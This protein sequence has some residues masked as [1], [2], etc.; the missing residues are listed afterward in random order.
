MWSQNLNTSKWEEKK[1]KLPKGVYNSLRQDLEDLIF[2]SKCLDGTSYL[3]IN[4]LNNI[5]DVFKYDTFDNLT[6]YIDSQYSNDN[7]DLPINDT[8]ID[9]YRKYSLEYGL[10]LKNLFTPERTIK[11]SI[12]NFLTVDIATTEEIEFLTSPKPGLKI[13]N[14]RVKPNH[15]VLV[16]DQQTIVTLP[17]TTNPDVYFDGNYYIIEEDTNTT[18]YFFYNQENGIYKFINNSLVKESDLDEYED[19]VRY[20]IYVKLGE[21][22]KEKQYHLSRLKGGFYPSVDNNDPVEFLENK[23]WLLRNKVEYQNILDIDIYD[24]LRHSNQ[25]LNDDID[26]II[27]QRSVYVGEF[28]SILIHQDEHTNS[29]FTPNQG[30]LN[31]IENEVKND[32]FSI[33]E[34]NNYYWAVGEKGTILR[35]DK[36]DLSLE[37]I[38]LD[39]LNNL[40]S[41]SFFNQLRGII[42]GEFNQIW[43]T[44][45][46]GNKW[47]QLEIN[48]F[49]NFK[50]N[51]VIF[52]GLNSAIIVGDNGI[53]I[54]LTYNGNSWE[55]KLLKPIRK[56]SINEEFDLVRNLNDII[57]IETNTWGLS[58]SNNPNT[59]GTNK[60]F[61][62]IVGDDNLLMVYIKNNFITD[63][64]YLFL[65]LNQNI[66]NIK[67]VVN[68]DDNIY[69]I[70]DNNHYRFNLNLF[71]SVDNISNEIFTTNPNTQLQLIN[72]SDYNNIYKFGNL[73][74]LVGD[75]L[76]LDFYD[77]T[78]NPISIQSR[79]N[80]IFEDRLKSKL[81]FVDYDMG[82]KLN[83]FG[84]DLEYRLPQEDEISLCI[85]SSSQSNI[86]ISSLSGET[87]W[88]DYHRDRLKEFEY[89]TSL[90]T[91]NEILYNTE[92]RYGITP[93][94]SYVSVTNNFNDIEDILDSNPNINTNNTYQVFIY[95]KYTVFTAPLG[96]DYQLGDV[97]EV[98]CDESNGKFIIIK[99]ITVGATQ[100]VYLRTNF[101]ETISNNIIDNNNSITFNNLNLFLDQVDFVDKFNKHYLGI[102]YE[103]VLG[104]P[105]STNGNDCND[106][107]FKP[108]YDEKNAYYNLAVKIEDIT[109]NNLIELEYTQLFLNFKYTATYNILDYLNNIN[110]LFTSNKEFLTMPQFTNIPVN[111]NGVIINPLSPITVNKLSFNSSLKFEWDS[112]WEKTFIDIDIDGYLTEKC[113]ILRKYYDSDTDRYIVELHKEINSP[114]LPVN[115][116]ILS[117]RTLG[118]ISNDLNE[119]NN[120]QTNIKNSTA[121]NF[122]IYEKELNFKFNTDSY[123]KILLSDIDIK[124][125][126]SAIMY[127][128]YKNEVSLNIIDL[129]RL[130][131]LDV[132]IESIPT[133]DGLKAKVITTDPHNLSVGDQIIISEPSGDYIGF[134]TVRSVVSNTQFVTNASF[135]NSS[136]GNIRIP[137]FDPY[138]SY[139]PSDIIDVGI[140]AKSKISVAISPNN[141]IQNIDN[142]LSLIDLDLKNYKFNLIDGLYL[143]LLS[144]RYPW[145]LE[146]EITKATIGI[147]ENGP[148]FYSG[149]W[150]CGRWFEG[151]WYSGTWLSGNW[152]GGEW[153]SNPVKLTSISAKVDT[154]SVG[155]E[156]SQWFGG[157]HHGGTWNGGTWYN[158]RWID[159]EWNNGIWFFG[160]WDQGTWNNGEF[161]S[162][163]WIFG[164]WNNG[165]FNST[166]GE[167][168][169]IDGTWYGGDFESGTWLNGKFTQN[170]GNISRFGTNPTNSR[171]AIWKSGGFFLGQFHSILN[172]DTDG[173][174]L[175]SLN[176]KYSIWET[177]K[178]SNG[179]WYGGTSLNI[180]WNNGIW[181]DGVSKEIEILEVYNDYYNDGVIK[182]SGV[183]NFNRNDEFFIIDNLDPTNNW[184]ELGTNTNPQSY[185]VK[186]INFEVI[187][188]IETN[189]FITLYDNIPNI[190]TQPTAT[191]QITGGN[192][193]DVIDIYYNSILSG[194]LIASVLFNVNPLQTANDIVEEINSNNNGFTAFNN[195]GATAIVTITKQQEASSFN[196][197][198]LVLDT[199]TTFD[200]ISNFIGGVGVYSNIEST[201]ISRFKGTDWENGLWYNGI[202]EGDIFRSGMWVRGTFLDGEFL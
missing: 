25:I 52:N 74:E 15:R 202:F 103:V 164:T 121:G 116:S 126:L 69:I 131:T 133:V 187:N 152:Y 102:S 2:Y 46:G 68:I 83:F 169:W 170:N 89:D 7:G 176:H 159:G 88:V 75:N 199:T 67:K 197:T 136:S 31:I 129:E 125:N 146:A 188:N 37:L 66:N 23:N 27:P 111:N 104:D 51:K 59:V 141:V 186:D 130:R 63:H 76:K 21:E 91:S 124:D 148:I 184:Q 34:T 100:Y 190:P 162:G 163:V 132:T 57:R 192:N 32:L 120:I 87:S 42:V 13:D 20:S 43:Y 157:N 142:T 123:T 158:G 17:N 10:T 119:I 96:I 3:P 134:Q 182:L 92:F 65:K 183:Y 95:D 174:T 193:G 77:S 71:E 39:V 140:D 16:K 177:G 28:G 84:D 118:E 40:T 56:E 154:N 173:D 114:M 135:N 127:T 50:Y 19:I 101:N 112:L 108:K 78:S 47:T 49:N 150:H 55:H 99:L 178:W 166:Q 191:L 61:Y 22:N 26:T 198:P 117:R 128:D 1:D 38:E 44:L 110:P 53:L 144:E 153:N 5:Y 196:G 107:L 70:S 161:N 165:R 94:V 62:L 115:I 172:Q 109:F 147:D 180:L 72:S 156:F 81:L 98:D 12:N 151:T 137:I 86:E 33:D 82:S 80:Q 9:N 122:T 60:D 195:D 189:T 200:I 24:S 14:V 175:P 113:F 145:I 139:I 167:S 201:V 160:Q 149:I 41:I 105:Y 58:Y 171:K 90:I 4:N 18:T 29:N 45:N 35:I 30:Y 168:I 185:L 85:G 54:E 93:S 73:I 48:E 181:K 97:I 155:D 11:D 106:I 138:L 64:K 8:T 179:T 194:D 79:V 6:W 36:V 143:D